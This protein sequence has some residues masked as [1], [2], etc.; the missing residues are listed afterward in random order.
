MF[1]GVIQ[2]DKSIYDTG[3]YMIFTIIDPDLD[4]DHEEPD[5]VSLDVIGWSSDQHTTTLNNPAFYIEPNNGHF[6]RIQRD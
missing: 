1:N 3:E 6:T 5:L 4:L 2:T